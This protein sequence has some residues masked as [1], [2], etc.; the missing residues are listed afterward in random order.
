MP[1]DLK[2]DIE[3]AKKLLKNADAILII[4]GAGMSVDSGIPTYRGKDGIW[5]KNIQIGNELFAYDE[6]SSL[7]MW[8][9]N[10]HLAW[11]FKSHFYNL[12]SELDPHP[13]Y[14]K[15]LDEVNSKYEYFICTSNIDGYF[16]RAGFDTNNIYEVHG[17]VNYLQCMDKNCNKKKWCFCSRKFTY[18]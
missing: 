10:P 7:N 12:M 3:A 5:T 1:H 18:L 11:G 9:K 15:L 17:S 8:K 2:R 14:Y 13:G 4:T 6:I 16:K